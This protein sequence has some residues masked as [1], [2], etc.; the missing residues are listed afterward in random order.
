[1]SMA[2]ANPAVLKVVEPVVTGL[3][4]ELVGVEF[5]SQ[6]RHSL[7]RVYLDSETGITVDDCERVS[8]Q[9]SATLDVEDPIGGAYTLEVSSPGL[10]RPLFKPG[11]FERFAGHAVKIRLHRPLN[12]Q[13][14]FKGELVGLRDNNVVIVED[15]HELSLPL[16]QIEKANLVPVL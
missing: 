2:H 11:D 9:L 15:G 1:M 12:G 14:K 16:D 6:G 7:L 13:R 3:G 5:L 10:D 4:Y 8:H